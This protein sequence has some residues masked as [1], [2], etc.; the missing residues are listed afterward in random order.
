MFESVDCSSF[1]VVDE[2]KFVFR[3]TKQMTITAMTMKSSTTPTITIMINRLLPVII[4]FFKYA[5]VELPSEK[6]GGLNSTAVT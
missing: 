6:L 5:Q 4:R 1:V 3:L 2:S